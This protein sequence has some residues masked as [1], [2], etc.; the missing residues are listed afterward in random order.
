MSRFFLGAETA[1]IDF[2]DGEFVDVKEE[3]TQ[4]DQDYV[5]NQMAHAEAV[6]NKAQVSMSLGR[7]ALLERAIV[8]WSFHDDAG[9]SVSVTKENISSLRLKYRSK[10]LE[11]VNRLNESALQFVIKND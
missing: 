10:I 6:G 7:L 11:E 9:Q 4:A 5:L 8:A 1:R 2:P 3:L